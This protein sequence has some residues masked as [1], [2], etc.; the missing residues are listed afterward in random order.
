MEGATA[1]TVADAHQKDLK[2][3]ENMVYEGFHGN[4]NP[5]G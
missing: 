2:L 4:N 3:Q 5:P 1:R